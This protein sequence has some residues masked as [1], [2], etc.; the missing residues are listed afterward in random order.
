[1]GI[2]QTSDE[3]K[4]KKKKK[5]KQTTQSSMSVMASK[6]GAKAVANQQA[7]AEGNTRVAIGV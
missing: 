6:V 1:M 3:K 2:N 4:K 5:G 7:K